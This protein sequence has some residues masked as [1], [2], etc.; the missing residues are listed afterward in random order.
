[1]LSS[2]YEAHRTQLTSL[3]ISSPDYV[4]PPALPRASAESTSALL[5]HW[6]FGADSSVSPN[7]DAFRAATFEVENA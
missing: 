6:V 3:F 2:Y 7:C 5:E 4:G 1:M